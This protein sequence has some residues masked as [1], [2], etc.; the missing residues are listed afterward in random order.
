MPTA[1][2]KTNACYDHWLS[3]SEYFALDNICGVTI[4]IA[5]LLYFELFFFLKNYKV[6][7]KGFRGIIQFKKVYG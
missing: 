3:D 7:K 5:C 2:G 6:T 1:M 4:P